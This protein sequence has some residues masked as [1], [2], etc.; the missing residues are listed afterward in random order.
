MSARRTSGAEEA[1]PS[2]Q[3]IFVRERAGA[4]APADVRWVTESD[5]E[6]G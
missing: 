5:S 6:N 2:V 1:G 4:A 3:T